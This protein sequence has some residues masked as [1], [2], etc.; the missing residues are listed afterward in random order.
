MK[1]L[2]NSSVLLIINITYM[3]L[4]LSRRKSVKYS[5]AILAINILIMVLGSVVSDILLID[6]VFYKYVIFL[7]LCTLI[8]YIYLVFDEP[9]SIKIFTCITV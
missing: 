6:T 1:F 7:L 2:I 9:I 3:N 8:F 5:S 4:L